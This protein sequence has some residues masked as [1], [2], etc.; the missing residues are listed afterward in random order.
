MLGDTETGSIRWAEVMVL[1]GATTV[2]HEVTVMK[3]Q[4]LVS[5]LYRFFTNICRSAHVVIAVRSSFSEE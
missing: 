4:Y 3:V 2:F 5:I 1:S